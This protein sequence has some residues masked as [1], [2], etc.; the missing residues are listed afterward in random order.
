LKRLQERKKNWFETERSRK[1][2]SQKEAQE[3]REQTERS[4]KYYGLTTNQK[5]KRQPTEGLI[6]K[7]TKRHET[8]RMKE[9]EEKR[10]DW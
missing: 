3:K 2:W 9:A 7:K 5:K 1:D 8:G 4:R 6:D 10:R